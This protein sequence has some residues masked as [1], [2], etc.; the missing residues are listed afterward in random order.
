MRPL[1]PTHARVVIPGIE[2]Q[3]D[4]EED[5]RRAP[6]PGVYCGLD[7]IRLTGSEHARHR[8]RQTLCRWFGE[9]T[10]AT[11]GAMYFKAGE[12]WEPGVQLS[13]DHK[14]DV[15]MV[16][17]RGER[18]RMMEADDAVQLLFDIASHGCKATR[19]D[20]AIDYVGQ[21]VR[22][23]HRAL[24]SC[25]AGELCRLRSYEPAY[26]K[27]VAG[28]VE[29]RLLKLGKRES[30]VCVRIYDK[31]LEQKVLPEGC[32]ERYEVEFKGDH[33]TQLL[34]ALAQSREAWLP[35]AASYAAGACDFR[36][37]NGRRELARRPRV[38]WWDQ[39]VSSL[40][41][42]RTKPQ[43]KGRT[44]ERWRAGFRNSYAPRILQMSGEVGVTAGELVRWL[45]E[46]VT[47]DSRDDLVLKEFCSAWSC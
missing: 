15:V 3:P 12:E 35:L 40:N 41:P 47:P 5:M 16:D 2:S 21:D 19:L 34:H 37:R 44:F 39:M 25:E 13:W 32:W 23:Y 38:K 17:V 26:A 43:A 46:G 22:L 42:S 30:A 11:H 6:D 18:L 45:T 9:Q 1:E 7:W 10:R 4:R 24:E 27:N 20:V 28:I 14:D 8:I 36:E 29:K 33:A 31:G